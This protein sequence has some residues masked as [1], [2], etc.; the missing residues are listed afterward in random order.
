MTGTLQNN[1]Q[2]CRGKP[3]LDTR[4]ASLPTRAGDG[5]R[6]HDILLGKQAFYH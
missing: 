1:K 3:L 5:T 4:A 6:T 2:K